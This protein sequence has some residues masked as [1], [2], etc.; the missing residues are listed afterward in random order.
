MKRLQIFIPFVLT[1]FWVSGCARYQNF[2]TLAPSQDVT[3]AFETATIL[4]DH[5]YYYTGPEAKP[6]A[7]MALAKS[8]TLANKRNFWI[9]LDIT[10][11]QLQSWNLIIQNETRIK[12]PYTGYQIITPDGRRAGVWYSPYGHTVV[13]TPEQQSIIVYTPDI[14]VENNFHVDRFGG[15]AF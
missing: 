5:T 7:I 4:P 6:D 11:E 3:R 10:K 15:R 2:G 9:K 12:F 14:P 8:F 1:V 13:K